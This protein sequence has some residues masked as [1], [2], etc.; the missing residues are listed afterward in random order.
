MSHISIPDL[1]VAFDKIMKRLEMEGIEQLKFE[2]DLY[3]VIHAED[4]DIT[5]NV[6]DVVVV[7]SLSDDVESIKKLAN[8]KDR[9]CTSVD[10]DRLA[11][12]LR[13]IG[14]IVAK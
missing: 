13:A 5:N 11:N 8:D 10:F 3:N 14:A 4:W 6:E 1:R 9:F 12:I 7:G 2:T